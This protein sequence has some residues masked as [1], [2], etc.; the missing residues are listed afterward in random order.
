[1]NLSTLFEKQLDNTLNSF[2][3]NRTVY[4]LKQLI[5]QIEIDNKN[6]ERITKNYDEFRITRFAI[7]YLNRNNDMIKIL[8]EEIDRR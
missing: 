7:P 3:E 2:I 4:E 5:F 1:M 6:Y 8:K